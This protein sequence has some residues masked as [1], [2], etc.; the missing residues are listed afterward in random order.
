M[1]EPLFFVLGVLPY[2]WTLWLPEKSLAYWG[3]LVWCCSVW[4]VYMILHDA[5]AGI[6]NGSVELGIALLR[7]WQGLRR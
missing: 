5:R 2:W 4:I 1:T 6:V 7:L 3:L